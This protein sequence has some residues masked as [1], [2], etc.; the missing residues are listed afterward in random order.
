[1]P[2]E[3]AYMFQ[4]IK[5]NAAYCGTKQHDY[6]TQKKNMMTLVSTRGSD[7]QAAAAEST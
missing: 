7:G 2:P 6:S 3:I 1:M 5:Y 4:G